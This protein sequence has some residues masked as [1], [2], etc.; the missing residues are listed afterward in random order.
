VSHPWVNAPIV[1]VVPK[2]RCWNREHDSMPVFC[3]ALA[4]AMRPGSSLFSTKYFCESHRTETDIAIP[5]DIVF[6]RVNITLS[7][8]V[9]GVSMHAP[10]AQVE[11][12]NL[13]K[14]ALASAAMVVTVLEVDSLVCRGVVEPGP[15]K[16]RRGSGSL[17]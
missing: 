11:A 9:A 4:S 8:L 2:M 6:R 14:D 17:G 7:V 16:G 1:A 12:V 5:S 15:G 3:G 10:T 13:V